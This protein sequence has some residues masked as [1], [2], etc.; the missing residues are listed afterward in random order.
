VVS[1][2]DAAAGTDHLVSGEGLRNLGKILV[3]MLVRLI[4]ELL[5]LIAPA[6]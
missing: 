5:R 6:I 3:P 1:Q 2:D 4:P